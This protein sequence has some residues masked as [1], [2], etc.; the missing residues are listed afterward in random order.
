MTFEQDSNWSP[1]L[2]PNGRIM[3]QR[4][5]YTDAAHSNSRMLFSMNPDGTD[6]RE[7]RGSGSWFPGAFF[8]ARPIPGQSRQ[9]IGVAGGHHDR[10]RS[11]RLF[12]FDTTQGR[13]D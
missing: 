2:L 5:E 9:V 6:Q 7:L 11:G 3:Y 10:S 4:W 12:I 13:R 1:T 8:F